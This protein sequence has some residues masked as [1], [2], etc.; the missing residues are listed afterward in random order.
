MS[1]Q[2]GVQGRGR[3]FTD[4]EARRRLLAGV[5]VTERRLDL[6]GGS[7]AVL[8][9]GDGPPMVLLHGGIETG[10][11]YWAPVIAE[12]S[13]HA[14]VIVPDLPG[15]GESEPVA[16]ASDGAFSEWLS[17]LLRMTCQE[18]PVLVAHSL[19]GTAGTRFAADHGE[20]LRRLVL[21]ATP[22]IG[23]YRMPLG[24][25]ATAIRF[26]LRPTQRNNARFAEWA[27]LDPV[28]TRRRDPEWYDAFMAY[29]LSRGTVPHV[30]R[31]MRQLI[32]VCTKETPDGDLRR[33]SVP[34]ALLWGRL[35]RMVPLHIAEIA[36]S[37]FGW[38]LHVIDDVGHVPFIEQP[39]AFL[40][41]L[42]AVL[43]PSSSERPGGGD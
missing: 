39:D 13:R 42:P 2:Q 37:R 16:L 22:G 5:P 10:G 20:R 21:M 26:S 14:R 9:G 15:L 18:P 17:Q 27:F 3:P 1:G 25:M 38:P 7:T 4:T 34:I 32:K 23:P 28:R 33:I 35:D 11:V 31:T 6:M 41:A 8:E 36:T 43:T 24:L 30:K 12:L 40:R 19:L 29:G